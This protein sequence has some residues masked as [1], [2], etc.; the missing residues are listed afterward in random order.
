LISPYLTEGHLWLGIARHHKAKKI[1]RTAVYCY[2]F[3]HMPYWLA[4]KMRLY[5]EDKNRAKW[6]QDLSVL[7]K[8]FSVYQAQET[9][10]W[11]CD[12]YFMELMRPDVLAVMREHRQKGDYIILLSGMFTEFLE[13]IGKRLR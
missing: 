2:I 10:N 7:F 11:I 3:S 8:G 4:A 12:N 5:P 6:G 13:V 1:R 9:F